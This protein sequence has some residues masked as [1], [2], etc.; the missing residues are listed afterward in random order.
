VPG[1]PNGS[2][3]SRYSG[4]SSPS[5]HPPEGPSVPSDRP[6]IVWLWTW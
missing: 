6:Q 1:P 5:D 3:S 4:G 2:G